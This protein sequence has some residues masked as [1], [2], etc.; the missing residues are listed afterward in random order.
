MYHVLHAGASGVVRE[1]HVVPRHIPVLVVTAHQSTEGGCADDGG[2]FADPRQ[3][4]VQKGGMGGE[5]IEPKELEEGIQMQVSQHLHE[6]AGEV[7]NVGNRSKS[8]KQRHFGGNLFVIVQRDERLQSS[9]GVADIHQLFL[10]GG[11]QGIRDL[12]R[13][14]I[15]SHLIKAELPEGALLGVQSGVL[16]GIRVPAAVAHPHVE[17]RIIQEEAQGACC[18]VHDPGV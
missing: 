5:P 3:K 9:L 4:E 10:G 14:V 17:P 6:R 2:F 18:K 13:K 16:Q 1:V 15:F 8:N 11:V 7:A 12:S